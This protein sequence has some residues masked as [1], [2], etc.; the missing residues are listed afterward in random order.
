MAK[1][2]ALSLEKARGH[3]DLQSAR[4]N[5]R[6]VSSRDVEG[7]IDFLANLVEIGFAEAHLLGAKVGSA[8]G[9]LLGRNNQ[10]PEVDQVEIQRSAA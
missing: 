6:D 3:F 1:V 5:L 9:S 4:D 10:M 2:L 8:V 7:R